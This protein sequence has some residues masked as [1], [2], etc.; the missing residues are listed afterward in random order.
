M[1]LFKRGIFYAPLIAIILISGCVHSTRA[2]DQLDSKTPKNRGSASDLQPASYRGRLALR[3]D[4]ES[5]PSSEGP[6]ARFFS[7][8]FELAGNA[9]QGELSLFTPLGGTVAVLS[10]APAMARLRA[11]GGV[12]DFESLPDLLKYATGTDIPVLGLFFWLAGDAVA[13]DGWRADLSQFAKGRV[14]ATRASPAPSIELRL[15]LEP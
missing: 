12:R 5:G 3:L 15:V 13:V 11:D 6:Q 8:G 7:G 2:T 10:W 4:A 14:S 9:Q 1:S